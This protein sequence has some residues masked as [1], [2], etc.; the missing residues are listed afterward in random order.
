MI[1]YGQPIRVSTLNLD[2][3]LGGKYASQALVYHV[4]P[5]LSHFTE[6]LNKL[7]VPLE[8]YPPE[9]AATKL[10]MKAPRDK[11]VDNRKP[12]NH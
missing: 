12:Y 6:N 1:Q 10:E 11:D 9:P 5:H 8:A 3:R 2:S 7:T 4:D